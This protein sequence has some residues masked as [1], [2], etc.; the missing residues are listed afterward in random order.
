MVTTVLRL[1][2]LDRTNEWSCPFP[3]AAR[4]PLELA[5]EVPSESHRELLDRSDA[6]AGEGVHRV[7][8]RV[9]GHDVR[10]VALGVHRVEVAA[11][12]RGD[13]DVLDLVSLGVAGDLDQPDL[14]LAVLVLAEHDLAHG[15]A[16]SVGR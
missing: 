12:L 9:R 15:L 10:V 14:R 3:S 11:E 6:V 16:P 2:S 1:S 4:D 8:L 13:A 5:G 7:L